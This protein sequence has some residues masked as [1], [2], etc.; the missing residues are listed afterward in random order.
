MLSYM[1]ALW[2][3]SVVVACLIPLPFILRKPPPSEGSSLG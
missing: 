2:V 1:N 3:L